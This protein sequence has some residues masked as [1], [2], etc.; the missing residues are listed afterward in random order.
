MQQWIR[1]RSR[2]NRAVAIDRDE[3][4]AAFE[5]ALKELSGSETASRPSPRGKAEALAIMHVYIRDLLE[6][7]TRIAKRTGAEVPSDKHVRVAADRI[8]I[9]RSRAG[10]VSDVSL[11]FGSV[12]L[13]GAFAFQVNLWTGGQA[14]EGSSIYAVGGLAVGIGLFVAAAMAK[15]RQS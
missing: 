13:G 11:G 15:W 6:E 5:E 7:A 2:P 9:L 10:F 1:Y 3:L 14:A 12:L 8:G 4:D